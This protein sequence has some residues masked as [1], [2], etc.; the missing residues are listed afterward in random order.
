MNDAVRYCK[1]E[2]NMKLKWLRKWKKF[3]SLSVLLSL[4]RRGCIKQSLIWMHTCS[5]LNDGAYTAKF[6]ENRLVMMM[7]LILF[8]NH[9]VWALNMETNFSLY[10]FLLRL[11]LSAHQRNKVVF[12]KANIQLSTKKARNTQKT[13]EWCS[14]AMYVLT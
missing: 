13:N 2:S 10:F 3:R 9:Y 6:M 1:R 7:M 12:A 4:Y 8:H 11:L 14:S 5:S